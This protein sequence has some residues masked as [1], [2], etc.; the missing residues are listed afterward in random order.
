[1]RH[2]LAIA[3]L[4]LTLG[5]VGST[6]AHAY[7]CTQTCNTVGNYTYCTTNCF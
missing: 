5:T 2:L 4:A 6:V 1:M 3:L 7:M